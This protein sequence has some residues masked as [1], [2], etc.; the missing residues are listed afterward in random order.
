MFIDFLL[1][2]ALIISG[3]YLFYRIQFFEEKKIVETPLFQSLLM[4]TLAVLSMLVPFSTGDRDFHVQCQ[5]LG[6]MSIQ[7]QH[8]SPSLKPSPSFFFENEI[9]LSFFTLLVFLVPPAQHL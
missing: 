2:I 8:L 1:N 3:I 4:T 9:I 6:C 7:L 5:L